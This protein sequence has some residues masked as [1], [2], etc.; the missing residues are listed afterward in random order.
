LNLIYNE[1]LTFL[2]D[3]GIDIEKYNLT[4]GYY[5]LDTAIIKAYDKQGNI[6]KIIRL[7]IDDDLKLSV[8]T[9]YENKPFEIESWG[10]TV[11]RNMEHLSIIENESLTLIKES[12]LKYN[13][14]IPKILTSGGK[15]S[16]V[17]MHLA[18]K[19]APN[20]EAL[21]SNTSL[22]CSD[23]YL[24]IKTLDNVRTINPQEGFYQWQKR[25]NFVPTRFARVCCRLFK[26][27]ATDILDSEH[28][29]L[30]FMGMRNQESNARSGYGDE[31][32]HIEWIEGWQ[33]I[34]PIR[35][36][37][38]EE[39]WLYILWRN[40]SVNSKYKKGY[41]RVGCS[42][43]CPFYTKSTW[44]L[45]KYWYPKMYNR[46]QNILEEDF[47]KNNKALIMNC[48][49]EEYK[50]KSWN[51]TLLRSEPTKE[52]I[53]EFANENGLDINV[54]EKY[55]SH[56]CEDCN[57][58]IRSKEVLAMNMKF[59]GRNTSKFYCKKHLMEK[60]EI[61]KEQWNEYVEGFKADKCDLF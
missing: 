18:R 51:G 10:E 8:K 48:T 60:L 31:W 29:Y 3:N 61:T 50:L 20:I 47:V 15:D 12:M 14:L 5:W 24:H 54:A 6:H 11:I 33:G 13:L 52:V 44:V 35:K 9:V 16:S 42:I 30:F 55:F 41:T 38:E 56:I 28:K 2:K 49:K 32:K 46:W 4:E 26:E 17:T 43:A 22:D 40:I 39:I 23:T 36:W 21:F 57:K 58:R 53:K 34:L 27:N 59:L 45:D 1:Y 25:T 37:T 19:V 7:L